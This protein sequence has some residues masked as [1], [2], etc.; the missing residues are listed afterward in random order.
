MANPIFSLF[1]QPTNPM[2]AQFMQFKKNYNGDAKQQVQELLNSG[3][4]TQEQY[5]RAVEMANQLQE[6]LK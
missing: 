4:I 6:L 5:N 2:V 3:K 1:N